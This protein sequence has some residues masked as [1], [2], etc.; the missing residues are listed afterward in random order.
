MTWGVG[1][2]L[3]TGHGW[4]PVSASPFLVLRP[5]N[6]GQRREVGGWHS[7][8]QVVSNL[9]AIKAG[10]PGPQRGACWISSGRDSVIEQLPENHSNK[11][12]QYDIADVI[13][14]VIYATCFD[15][16][17]LAFKYQN[18]WITRCARKHWPFL[19]WTSFE[20]NKHTLSFHLFRMGV[21]IKGN[22]FLMQTTTNFR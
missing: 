5:D 16:S 17:C 19:L 8:E 22:W 2:Y 18:C 9:L 20:I 12:K 7:R 11:Q 4:L 21:C 3:C 13:V 10:L 1:F 6:Y 14:I 15:F